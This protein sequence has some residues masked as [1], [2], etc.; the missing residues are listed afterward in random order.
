MTHRNDHC[1]PYNSNIYAYTHIVTTLGH[2]TCHEEIIQAEIIQLQ[3][4]DKI[5]ILF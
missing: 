5:I 4:N 3:D 1:Y 2:A